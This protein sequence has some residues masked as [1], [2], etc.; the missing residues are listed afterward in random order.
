MKIHPNIQNILV[1]S[2][3]FSLI[4]PCKGFSRE[5][6]PSPY[7]IQ[8]GVPSTIQSPQAISDWLSREFT[9][10]LELPDRWQAPSETLSSKMGDCEDFALLGADLLRRIGI[11]SD[12]AIVK[13]RD[14][15]VSHAICIWKNSEGSFD[16]MDDRRLRRTG[17]KRIE[18]AVGRYYPDWEKIV[19]VD[20]RK[21]TKRTI[22]RK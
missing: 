8:K 2:A 5:V 4:L 13:F 17:E 18:D 19:F 9:Y 11:E 21:R 1:F 3:L 14:L 12:I 22:R 6:E 15:N 20:S 16:F 10:R 7:S